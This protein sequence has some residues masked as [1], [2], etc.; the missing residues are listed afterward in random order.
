MKLRALILA[1]TVALASC[2][3]NNNTPPL[4]AA[5]VAAAA[6]PPVKEYQIVEKASAAEMQDA[7]NKMVH[8]GWRPIGGISVI[9]TGG[10]AK[11]MLYSQA[12]AK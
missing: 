5:D 12:V 4:S 2:G 8:D 7:V 1:A 3:G 11:S 10:D 9:A 6:R